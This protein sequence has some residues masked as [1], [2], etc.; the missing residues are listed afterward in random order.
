M[1]KKTKQNKKHKDKQ[2]QPD[3]GALTP[4][5]VSPVGHKP[6]P[7]WL[8]APKCFEGISLWAAEGIQ[9]GMERVA[10]DG[11]C[12][13]LSPRGGGDPLAVCGAERPNIEKAGCRKADSRAW[14]VTQRHRGLRVLP[15]S[16][17][18]SWG[19]VTGSLP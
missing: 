10:V 12:G 5:G 11:G 7:P 15:S 17:T 2:N 4:Q 6:L 9:G 16:L 19:M 8:Q 1:F 3:L 13:N 18:Q 14:Q